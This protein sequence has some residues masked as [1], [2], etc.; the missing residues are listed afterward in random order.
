MKA[1]L[2]LVASVL[3]LVIGFT[4]HDGAVVFSFSFSFFAID[5]LV[6]AERGHE[7]DAELANEDAGHARRGID[8][9]VKQITREGVWAEKDTIRPPGGF[10]RARRAL[11]N[12]LG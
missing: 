2:V 1:L 4:V 5:R 8:S 7:T 12:H 11:R 9:A 3:G 6:P 10:E